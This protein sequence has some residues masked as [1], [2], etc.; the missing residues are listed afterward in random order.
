MW[1]DFQMSSDGCGSDHALEEGRTA[2]KL[3]ASFFSPTASGGGGSDPEG[4]GGGN[5]GCHVV[6]DNNASECSSLAPVRWHLHYNSLPPVQMED[7]CPG[8]YT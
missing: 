4:S 3:A 5:R 7:D 6:C 1:H 2:Y 8:S